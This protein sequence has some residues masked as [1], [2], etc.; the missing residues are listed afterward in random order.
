MTA[1]TTQ[2]AATSASSAVSV[3][4]ALLLVRLRCIEAE[5]LTHIALIAEFPWPL[6]RLIA[7]LELEF[8]LTHTK[9]SPLRISNRKYFAIFSFN[10]PS[11]PASIMPWPNN[12]NRNSHT[13][14]ILTKPRN[15]T[16]YV[17]S[18]RNKIDLFAICLLPAFLIPKA[19]PAI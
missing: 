13:I 7:N 14:R 1:H 5:D 12:P 2:S 18:N 15:I 19:F 11:F 16:T 17:F 4:Q 3:A 6:W 9:L 10:P 8:H